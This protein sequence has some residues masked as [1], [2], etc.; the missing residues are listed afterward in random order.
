MK[1]QHMLGLVG[2]G[3]FVTITYSCSPKLERFN[4]QSS[5]R[6]LGYD[7][8][9]NL[10][11]QLSSEKLREADIETSKIIL[12]LAGRNKKGWLKR[13]DIGKL[14]CKYLEKLD[15]LWMKYSDG[16]FGFSAQGEVWLA[17][18]GES[19]VYHTQTD[20]L[21]R[22]S[23]DWPSSSGPDRSYIKYNFS[24]PKGHLPAEIFSQG[25]NMPFMIKKIDSCKQL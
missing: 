7:S 3:L 17:S 4:R 13:K 22:E 14:P 10:E 23:I 21:F 8:I 15:S 24:A 16:L 6:Y 12:K 11:R 9:E 25:T 19:G 2:L 18:G 1:V 5:S 20:K